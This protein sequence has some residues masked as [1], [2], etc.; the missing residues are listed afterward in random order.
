MTRLF[1]GS[2]KLL[3][4]VRFLAHNVDVYYVDVS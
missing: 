1:F 4:T 3:K 2:Y